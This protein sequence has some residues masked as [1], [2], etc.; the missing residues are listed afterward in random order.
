MEPVILIEARASGRALAVYHALT[1]GASS[2][3]KKPKGSILGRWSWEWILSHVLDLFV[4]K[5]QYVTHSSNR[6]GK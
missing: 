6:G 2:H 1:D 3:V 5:S 4:C